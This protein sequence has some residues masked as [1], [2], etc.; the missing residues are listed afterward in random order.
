MSKLPTEYQ[1]F[2]HM[3]RYSRW[4]DNEKRRETWEETVD[5]YINYMCNIQCKGMI[6]PDVQSELREGILN[7]EAMPS[8]RA[9][10]TAG[11]ALERDNVAGFNC[12]YVAIDDPKAFDEIMYILMCGS[13]VGFS[14]ERQFINE[15][16]RVS[17]QVQKSNTTIVIRDSKVGWSEAFREL[18]SLLYSGRIP[19]FDTSQ[20][21]LAGARL[22]T[23]GGRAC[24]TGDTIVYKDRKKSQG[25]NEITIKEL[26]DMQRGEGFWK[27]KPNHFNQVKIRSLDEQTG[28]FFR[29]NLLNVVYNGYHPVYEILTENGYRIKATDIHRFVN[30]NG[31]YDYVSNFNAGDFI[32][33]N[34]SS[35]SKTGTC[36]DCGMAISRRA[37]R[38][39]EC[40]NTS[41]VDPNALDTTARQRKDCI[42][43]RLDY[44]EQ[45][46]TTDTRFEVH[47]CD[48]DPHNN[49]HNN[50]LNLCSKCHQTHHAG[51]TTF[52]NPYSHRYVS[53]DRIVSIRHIGSDH[54]YD[55][56]MEG[57]NHN[58]IANGFVSHNSGPEPLL[59]LFKFVTHIF[60][61]AAG[62]KLTSIECHDIC[63][64]VGEIVVVGGVRRS[65]EIS[66][67]NPSDDRMRDAKSGE[68][69]KTEKQRT[70][71]NN[72][73]C[74]TEKPG[75]SKFMKEWLSLFES[76]S[77]ER[78]IFNREAAKK[79][80]AKY[81]RR[82]SEHEFGCN[83]CSEIIL[84]SAQFC[85]LSEVVIRESDTLETLKRKVRL[86]TIL[87]TMQATLTNFRYLREVW[88]T[89]TE[90]EAL[91]GVSL[92]GIT[93]NKT[94]SGQNGKDTLK[95][96]L[97]EL[98]V[99]AVAT[100]K[101][102][103]A[104]LGINQA[105]AVTCVK[106]SGTVS[107]L[108]DCASGIHPR[109][110]DM[111][112]RR[113]RADMK[114]PLCLMMIEQGFPW[115]P[116]VTKPKHNAVFSFPVKAPDGA[117]TR[118]DLS[119]LDHLDLWLTYQLE[120]CEH[121]PSCTINIRE[122]EWMQV[123]S[124]VYDNFDVVSGISFLPFN[125]HSY[126]QAPYEE[127]E[128]EEYNELLNQ[129]PV[130][131][132]DALGKYEDDD[133]TIGAQNLSCGGGDCEVV[134]VVKE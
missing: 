16:P 81:E 114:D 110:A 122:H 76:K 103:A 107:Q 74:Y 3:S 97:N 94:T 27:G 22:K 126:M 96:W 54:V 26:Y 121:K 31:E 64:K 80:A 6:P 71:A 91:L 108:V 69:W 50:L 67:S 102:W 88:K 104:K 9:M 132:W 77:G 83:P 10:M 57:P 38:C 14:I 18:I 115:E 123:G 46:G 42:D 124:W 61:N 51:M 17:E 95:Q 85:N 13:G 111:F 65:A 5:R 116:D 73:A 98:R 129:I 79:Q 2:I 106:P 119:A 52:G 128:K 92:T 66:L 72:S 35:E 101:E 34:G 32:A 7:L 68:W 134:D 21:R 127:F 25:Y 30:A 84:R 131:D 120:W 112:I 70:L 49:N 118:D 53:F 117:L 41:Q 40:F 19:K 23:F 29:N 99:E 90:E 100:N 55:L 82:D 86:A 78:G 60:K 44:C 89:N 12:S 130:C 37:M 45:C 11:P 87:G 125:D 1:K 133:N 109:H 62:R 24:L 39:V 15:L 48:G 93:D 105:A 47:H 56:Q 43:Y 113:V 63:C 28:Q 4:L 58:F 36:I 8:M 75:M 20:V 59:D 33:V